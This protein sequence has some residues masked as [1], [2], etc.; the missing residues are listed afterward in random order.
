LTPSRQGKK[1]EA[2]PTRLGK[3]ERRKKKKKKEKR[4]L[5]TTPKKREKNAPG[6]RLRNTDKKKGPG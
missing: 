3:G 6:Q 2:E 4:M 5:I 1:K